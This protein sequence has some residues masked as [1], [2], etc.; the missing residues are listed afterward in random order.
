M[1][2]VAGGYRREVQREARHCE[3]R[4]AT[5]GDADVEGLDGGSVFTP[6]SV[7]GER[8]RVWS[9]R[10]IVAMGSYTITSRHTHAL[11]PANSSTAWEGTAPEDGCSDASGAGCDGVGL[12]RLTGRPAASTAAAAAVSREITRIPDARS[13]ELWRSR[14]GCG[15][16][17]ESPR[18][19]SVRQRPHRSSLSQHSL[20][21]LHTVLH[22]QRVGITGSPSRMMYSTSNG[23]QETMEVTTVYDRLRAVQADGSS[24]VEALAGF[25]RERAHLEEQYSRS[26]GRLSKQ[27]LALNGACVR[28]APAKNRSRTPH[29]SPLSLLSLVSQSAPPTPPSLRRWPASAGTC[30]TRACST[31][32]SLQPLRRTCWTRWLS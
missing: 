18:K 8:R 22:A 16:P 5:G 17:R 21:G 14:S 25:M 31:W 6:M 27:S 28:G 3:A 19:I 24:L 11:G 1:R 20:V 32:S 15:G 4:A 30:P 13:D 9:I 2:R 7:R 10:Q 26:L 12:P 29:P 23:T